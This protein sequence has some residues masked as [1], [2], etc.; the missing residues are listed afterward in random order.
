MNQMTLRVRMTMVLCFVSLQSVMCTSVSKN[1]QKETL[2]RILKVEEVLALEQSEEPQPETNLKAIPTVVAAT[3]TAAPTAAPTVVA[4]T[5]SPAPVLDLP[6]GIRTKPAPN[7]QQPA[8]MDLPL[9]RGVAHADLFHFINIHADVIA[10]YQPLV[11][12]SKIYARVFTP[13]SQASVDEISGLKARVRENLARSHWLFVWGVFQ[14]SAA[15]LSQNQNLSLMVDRQQDFVERMNVLVF[16]MNE[17][18]AAGMKT[19]H[20]GFLRE[21]Y[22]HVNNKHFK[23][24]MRD[25]PNK[26]VGPL[27]PTQ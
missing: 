18:Q 27:T 24:P 3:P 19:N 22:K 20:R 9:P 8:R 10:T 1:E 15:L 23:R 2:E 16:L 21:F 6:Y 7:L 13:A 17:M 12:E 5:P 14:S 11:E 26:P 4:A 25:R